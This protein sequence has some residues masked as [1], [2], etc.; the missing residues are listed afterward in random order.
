[1]VVADGL[2]V[3][4]V[5]QAVNLAGVVVKQL[6]LAHTELVGLG[7]AGVVGD[8]RDRLGGQPGRPDGPDLL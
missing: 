4:P 5:E 8:L 3:P 2:F 7:V 1:M 6:E